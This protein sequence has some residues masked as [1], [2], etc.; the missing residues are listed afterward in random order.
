ML[1]VQF[2]TVEPCMLLAALGA[3]IPAANHAQLARPDEQLLSAPNKGAARLQ[4][5]P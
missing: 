1:V 4:Q 2:Q 3:A 5:K